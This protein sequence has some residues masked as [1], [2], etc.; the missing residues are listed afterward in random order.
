M[1][2][3]KKFRVKVKKDHLSQI[4]S[5]SPELA[6]AEMIWNAL[7][8]D[9]TT[10]DVRFHEGPLGVDEITITDNGTGI[11]YGQAE[12]LF[13]ALGGSWKARRQK[14]DKGR[15]LHGKEGKGRFKAFV[16]GMVVVIV[17]GTLVVVKIFS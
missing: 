14:T 15:F 11:P 16:L 5:G 2:V 7:D 4:A 3:A 10:V 8:A 13:E 17:F 6:L 9:S 1:S 12:S